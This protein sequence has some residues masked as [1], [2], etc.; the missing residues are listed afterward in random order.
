MNDNAECFN[1]FRNPNGG[2]GEDSLMRWP[3]Y[4][5]STKFSLVFD[6]APTGDQNNQTDAVTYVEK[7]T[8][9]RYCQFWNSYYSSLWENSR[10]STGICS[11]CYLN[12]S[13]LH[14]S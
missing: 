3:E 11:L 8:K 1:S 10:P 2:G 13:T 5:E 7:D 12:V 4:H 14:Y 9:D 6:I